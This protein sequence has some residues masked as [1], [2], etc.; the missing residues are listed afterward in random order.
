[1][2]RSEGAMNHRQKICHIEGIPT[3]WPAGWDFGPFAPVPPGWPKK[4]D[5]AGVK[6]LASEADGQILLRVQDKW[7][8][9]TDI[10]DGHAIQFQAASGR[11]I[12]RMRVAED[13][14]W[15]EKLIFIIRD[16]AVNRKVYFDW[17]RAELPDAG[18]L[19]RTLGV[20]PCLSVSLR[21]SRA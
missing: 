16:G 18:V 12:V 6:L 3:D 17:Q 15:S 11:E 21:V 1:M 20:E 7:D 5:L 10:L 14:P 4:L 8:E 19:I 9:E 13:A 2:E